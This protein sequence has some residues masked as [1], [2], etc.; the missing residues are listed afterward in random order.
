M[1]KDQFTDLIIQRLSETKDQL[2][3]QFSLQHPIKVARHFVLDD[4][5]PADIA[6]RIYA[7]FPKPR[8]MRLLS[9]YGEL[10][11]KYSHIKNTAKLLQELNLAI[12]DARVVAI[13]EEITGIKNQVA[14]TSQQ[15]GGISA[16]FEGYYIN[17]HLDNSHDLQRKRYR[18]VNVLYYVSPNWQEENGGNYELWN[19]SV[20]ERIIVP[21]FFNRLVVMETNRT[22]W[23][24]VNPVRC[25]APRCCLF[26]YYFSEDSPEGEDYFHGP[27]SIF[28][29]PLFKA[30]PEQT[31]RRTLAK[32]R[33]IVLRRTQP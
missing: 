24:A 16:L 7:N 15:A 8:Q 5:L 2:K 4:L 22:S 25:Q 21:S 11:L 19:T 3:K 9:S 12:Q 33:D 28:F 6:E 32:L 14:D 1:L 29:N 10:K 31:V 17:P 26:N 13:I 30:R 20:T 18:T 27:S 23:H